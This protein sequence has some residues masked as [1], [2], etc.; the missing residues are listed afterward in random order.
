MHDKT[1]D[2]YLAPGSPYVYLGHSRLVALAREHRATVAVKPIDLGKVF[3]ASG[4]LPLGKRAPQ[5]QAYRL[6]ELARWGAYLN[7]PIHP[8]PAHFP[9]AGD[10]CARWIVAAAD[11]GADTALALVGVI[12]HALWADQEN[13]GDAATLGILA[14]SVGLDESDMRQRAAEPA[15]AARYAANTQEAL[16]LGVFGAPT[17]V[18]RGELFWGQDRLDFLARALAQ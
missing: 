4:G 18:Y 8:Q 3:P 14:R 6:V 13:P 15:V 12:G 11:K 9:L 16:D 17:Y 2:Y 7:L 5:R 1:I 10:E